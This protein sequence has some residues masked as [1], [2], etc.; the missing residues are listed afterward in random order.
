M[1]QLQSLHLHVQA[2]VLTE[3]GLDSLLSVWPP[4]FAPCAQW[5]ASPLPLGGGSCSISLSPGSLVLFTLPFPEHLTLV[6]KILLDLKPRVSEW[7]GDGTE[8][9]CWFAWCKDKQGKCLLAQSSCWGLF[10]H[11]CT[12]YGFGPESPWDQKQPERWLVPQTWGLGCSH[13]RF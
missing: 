6:A 7:Q 8:L 12:M 3:L 10:L 2:P 9:V 1:P 4:C 5:L 13:S 11:F